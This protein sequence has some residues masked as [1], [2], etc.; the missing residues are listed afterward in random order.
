[1]TSNEQRATHDPCGIRADQVWTD[2]ARVRHYRREHALGDAAGPA[3]WS[4]EHDC[5]PATATRTTGEHSRTPRDD[6][7]ARPGA[8]VPAAAPPVGAGELVAAVDGPLAG[9]WFTRADW[10][11]YVRD[12]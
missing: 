7:T 8:K 1:M 6:L 3:Q 12:A 2:S 5:N 11:G 4:E 10:R 9:Q